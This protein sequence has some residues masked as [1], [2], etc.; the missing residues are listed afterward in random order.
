MNTQGN[1]QDKFFFFYSQKSIYNEQNL[2]ELCEKLAR[3][4]DELKVKYFIRFYFVI[5]EFVHCSYYQNR[6]HQ[7]HQV[8]QRKK[9]VYIENDIENFNRY[10][11]LNRFLYFIYFTTCSSW[12]RRKTFTGKREPWLV[13]LKKFFAIIM[14]KR[15]SCKND[16]RVCYES[17]AAR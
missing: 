15:E 8:R 1:K 7:K 11:V 13:S 12:Y 10:F 9:K 5:N 6:N 3:Q 2:I 4:C 14:K 16:N 17:R